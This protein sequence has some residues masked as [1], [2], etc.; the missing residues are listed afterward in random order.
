MRISAIK[1]V[2]PLGDFYIAKIKARDLL[3]IST[4]QVARYD[5]NGNVIGNQRPINIKSYCKIHT[6]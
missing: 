2:Q 6:V 5:K 3:K 4:S 1:V